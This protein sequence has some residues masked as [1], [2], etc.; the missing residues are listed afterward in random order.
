M[1]KNR[2]REKLRIYGKRQLKRLRK[3]QGKARQREKL[4]KCQRHSKRK[5]EEIPKTG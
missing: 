1:P 3:C 5:V 2:L 4:R